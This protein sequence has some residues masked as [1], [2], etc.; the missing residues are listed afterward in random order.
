MISGQPANPSILD[1]KSVGDLIVLTLPA[2]LGNKLL[3]S[4]LLAGHGDAVQVRH[5]KASVH[6]KH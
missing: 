6:D 3:Q 4:P 1:N 5:I 2:E